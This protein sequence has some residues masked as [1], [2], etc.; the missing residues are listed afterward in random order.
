[1]LEIKNL[2][3]GYGKIE[4]LHDINIVVPDCQIVGVIGRNGAGKST[5][6]NTISGI[7]KTR[8]GEILLDG[9]QTPSAPH[10]VVKT[11]I[12]QVPEGRRIFP[13]LTVKE[14]LIMGAYLASNISY[15]EREE[16]VFRLFPIL[17]ERIN[18]PSGTLSGGE[19][20]MLAMG[21]GL[22]SNPKVLLLDEPSL[23]LAPI[24]FRQVFEMIVRC[25]QE[26]GMTIILVEQNARMAL[27]MAHYAYV[28]E[29]GEIVIQGTGQE[30]LNDHR[31][32]SAY[33]GAS[34]SD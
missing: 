34:V 14:N 18:Q 33:L 16:E 8:S 12:I 9:V 13:S 24:L 15:D 31:V 7:V 20:Q 26:Q 10:K 25:N 30:L 1:M 4:V 23:G 3:S 6:L 29:D 28:L 27:K 5:L 11:G 21:R 17:K 22:M 19:Q 2:H 32:Q